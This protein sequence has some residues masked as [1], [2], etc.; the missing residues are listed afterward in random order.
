[1]ASPLPILHDAEAKPPAFRTAAY[2]I[3]GAAVILLLRYAAPV[4]VPIVLA[5]LIGYA[6]DPLVT[7]L[8]A[9]RV[10]R[11]AAAMLVVLLTVGGLGGAVYLMRTHL[12]TVLES[13]PE[14]ARRIRYTVEDALGDAQSSGPLDKIKEAATEI[15]KTADAA[16]GPAAPKA[17][18]TPVE[19]EQ[20]R[21]HVSDF[22]WTGSVGFA[23]VIIQAG[24]VVFLVYFLLASGDLYKRKLVRIVGG[25]F[26]QKRVT[27]ETLHE[28]DRQIE[29]FLIVQILT[30]V[31]VG[32]LTWLGLDMI[33]VSQ[34]AI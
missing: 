14:T 23:G 30:S 5:V 20:T 1:V 25:D 15:Q 13:L 28:I 19:V 7:K 11:A 16:T 2:V 31:F 18:V 9:W 21:F 22:I 29:R 33:G 12:V 8:S 32:V 3:S 4:L 26:S 27:V 17:G 6:L 34:P 24:V 10:P